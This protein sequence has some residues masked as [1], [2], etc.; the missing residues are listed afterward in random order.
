MLWSLPH[1]A[2]LNN[3]SLSHSSVL[4]LMMPLDTVKTRLQFQGASIHV[5]QYVVSSMCDI[6]FVESHVYYRYNHL[7]LQKLYG[8]ISRHLQG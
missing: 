6:A 4:A 8:C 7:Q 5:K 3:G 1:A 2:H